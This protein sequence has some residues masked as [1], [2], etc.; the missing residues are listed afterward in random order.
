MK[1]SK[2][3]LESL[4]NRRITY[5]NRDECYKFEGIC[6]DCKYNASYEYA[7]IIFWCDVLDLFKQCK[8]SHVE[9]CPIC[10]GEGQLAG[11]ITCYGC[12]G[13]GWVTVYD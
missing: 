12:D 9:K 11:I 6:I 13:K 7:D 3:E 1:V 2:Q 10:N 5:L 4:V 8:S